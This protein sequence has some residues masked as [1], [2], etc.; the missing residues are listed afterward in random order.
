MATVY[1]AGCCRRCACA[2]DGRPR[3]YSPREH[4]KTT[5]GST[6]RLRQL[7]TGRYHEY[8]DT[9]SASTWERLVHSLPRTIRKRILGDQSVLKRVSTPNALGIWIERNQSTKLQSPLQFRI[10]DDRG[11]YEISRNYGS[12][13]LPTLS[14]VSTLAPNFPHSIFN[15]QIP[16]DTNP[17]DWLRH[18]RANQAKRRLVGTREKYFPFAPRTNSTSFVATVRIRSLVEVNF[19]VEPKFDTPSAISG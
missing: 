15:L 17:I 14:I 18:K 3:H 13:T 4:R 8:F 16:R 11:N 10:R 7:T 2:C 19:V 12:T 9:E 6:V 1:N 5:D